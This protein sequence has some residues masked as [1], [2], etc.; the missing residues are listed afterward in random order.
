LMQ[1]DRYSELFFLDEAT[2]LA[3]GHRPCGECRKKE[4]DNFKRAWHVAHR[5]GAAEI[6]ITEIDK[7]LHVDRV[8]VTKEKQTFDAPLGELPIGAMFELDGNV[9]LRWKNG[10]VQWTPTGYRVS[11]TKFAESTLV[12]VLTPLSIVAVFRAGYVPQVHRSASV[13]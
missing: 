7:K 8:T 13:K 9:F 1:P 11:T 3:A 6:F 10:P 12:K 5:N 4:Y 2:A